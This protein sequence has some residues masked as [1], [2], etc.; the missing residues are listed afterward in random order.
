[1]KVTLQKDWFKIKKLPLEESQYVNRIIGKYG[2]RVSVDIKRHDEYVN[3]LVE[4]KFSR[5][6][7]ALY[8]VLFELTENYDLEV[9]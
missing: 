1:M 4:S 5:D 7:T 8:E 6:F 2:E 9:F 3:I